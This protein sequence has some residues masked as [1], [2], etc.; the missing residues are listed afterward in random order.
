[1]S[2]QEKDTTR[3]GT[4]GPAVDPLDLIAS[5][6]E[7]EMAPLTARRAQLEAEIAELAGREDRI[8]AA[9]SAL[10]GVAKAHAAKKPKGTGT[11]AAPS[12]RL[13]DDVYA[14]IVQAE[15][16]G[17]H[18]TIVQIAE[19]LGTYSRSAIDNAVRT[20]RTNERIRIVGRSASA[21][22]PKMYG[23]MA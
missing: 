11:Q 17:E 18:L 2:T 3:N 15:R 10:K 5:Q 22:G 23:T 16:N 6:L 8:N 12:Q 4:A 7:E 1:M 21:G 19:K 9:L 20:L 13:L 14:T